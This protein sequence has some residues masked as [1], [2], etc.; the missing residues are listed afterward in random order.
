M[1]R[2]FSVLIAVYNN[3]NPTY[4]RCALESIFNQSL[5]ADEIIL[6]VD[7]PINI[8]LHN[9][10]SNYLENKTFKPTF[11][12][13]NVGFGRALNF[14]LAKCSHNLIIRCDSDD[15]NIFSRFE[16]QV[17]YMSNNP[18][19]VAS[20]SHVD[21]IDKNGLIIGRKKVPISANKIR[22]YSKFFSPLNHPAVIFRKIPVQNLGG[23]PEFRYS[24]D[25]ALWS[26]I[27]KNNHTLSN[28]DL[29]LVQM[30]AD[31]SMFKRRGYKNFKF[32]MKIAYY[33]YKIG[34]FPF[35][36]YLFNFI[37]R[38]FILMS[39]STIKKLYYTIKK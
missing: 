11:L 3:D 23:Y 34:F 22:F 13:E 7:G 27:L 10:I 21:Y 14:G 18:D 1:N 15:I 31:D 38:V 12:P 4:F 29:V 30:R 20:S 37:L 28:L 19:I 36:L 39:G 25:H 33:K 8:E 26:L 35:Y 6:I 16:I 32:E 9:V 5:P 2:Q 24:Q 17:N